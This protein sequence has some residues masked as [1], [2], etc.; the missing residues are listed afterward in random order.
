M[1]HNHTW[2]Q[3][4][5]CEIEHVNFKNS[6]GKIFSDFLILKILSKAQ[7]LP[8]GG[9][10]ECLDLTDANALKFIVPFLWTK[11]T[12]TMTIT[13]FKRFYRKIQRPSV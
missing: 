7:V 13:S 8:G 3:L 9:G 6:C 1:K 11:L 12:I 10:C 4:I 5:D 2:F